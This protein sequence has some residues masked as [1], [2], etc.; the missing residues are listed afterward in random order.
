M[1]QWDA[2]G[3]P[4]FAQP[5]E[6]QAQGNVVAFQPELGPEIVRR[7]GTAGV[8]KVQVTLVPVP[9]AT[10]ASVW[11]FYDTTCKSGTLPFTLVHPVS[12]ATV[13]ARFDP[14]EPPKYATRGPTLTISFPLQILP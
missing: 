5:W 11:T 1:A 9:F 12:G 7:R 3:L 2:A 10:W 6:E 14:K 13:T 4:A 8:K